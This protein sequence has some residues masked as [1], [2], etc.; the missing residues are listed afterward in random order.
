M[1]NH[2]PP[3]VT[4]R[5][6]KETNNQLSGSGV[7]A[8]GRKFMLTLRESVYN[9]LQKVADRRGVTIQGL[10]R[11]VIVPEWHIQ[12]S[13]DNTESLKPEVAG[14]ERDGVAKESIA[15]SPWPKIRGTIDEAG[16]RRLVAQE[17][18]QD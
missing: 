1:Q 5:G 3:T 10:I 6:A 13:S 15:I 18:S 16:P 7:A 11:A 4:K 2:R 9:E 12:H 14:S 17:H 8:T